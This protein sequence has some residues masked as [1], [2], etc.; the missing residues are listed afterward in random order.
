MYTGSVKKKEEK[1]GKKKKTKKKRQHYVRTEHN[2]TVPDRVNSLSQRRSDGAQLLFSNRD[3]NVG[4]G[5]AMVHRFEVFA[6]QNDYC[7]GAVRHL[8]IKKANT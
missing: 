3:I 2:F 5:G 1:G 7:D 8:R 6:L 4:V